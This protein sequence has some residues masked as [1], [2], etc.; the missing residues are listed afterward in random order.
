VYYVAESVLPTHADLGRLV[1]EALG[2][3]SLRVVRVPRAV[4]WAAAAASEIG[5]RLRRRPVLMNLDKCREIAA[6]SWT[7]DAAKAREQLLFRPGA[8][9]V[10]RLRQTAAWYR[11]AQWLR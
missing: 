7:C 11:E 9:V 4:L 2:R 6:G 8:T 5:G 3:S 1:A 10:E